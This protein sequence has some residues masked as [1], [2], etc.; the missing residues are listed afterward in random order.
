MYNALQYINTA[1]VGHFE[2]IYVVRWHSVCFYIEMFQQ[3]PKVYK[4]NFEA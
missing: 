2:D 3:R 1:H 4:N